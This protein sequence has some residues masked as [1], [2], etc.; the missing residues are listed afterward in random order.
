MEIL[1]IYHINFKPISTK[2][3][4]PHKTIDNI[5]EIMENF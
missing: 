2:F 5:N 1:D 4:K 3:G